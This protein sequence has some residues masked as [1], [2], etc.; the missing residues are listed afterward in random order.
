M[1]LIRELVDFKLAY[2]VRSRVTV[3]RTDAPDGA[4]RRRRSQGVGQTS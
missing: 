3:S 2:L 4:L 1:K